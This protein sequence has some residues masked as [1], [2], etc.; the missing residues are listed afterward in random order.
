MR[1]VSSDSSHENRHVTASVNR[2]ST[3][4]SSKNA[5]TPA[6]VAYPLTHHAASAGMATMSWNTAL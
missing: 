1:L 3:G 6:A 2:F 5:I 4:S